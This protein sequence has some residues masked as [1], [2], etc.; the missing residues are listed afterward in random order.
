MERSVLQKLS[1]EIEDL[2][3]LMWWG[4]ISYDGRRRAELLVAMWD[5]TLRELDEAYNRWFT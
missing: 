1:W 5:A 4:E 3:P 2:M